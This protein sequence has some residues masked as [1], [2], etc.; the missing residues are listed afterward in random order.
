[1]TQPVYVV[2]YNRGCGARFSGRT[3]TDNPYHPAVECAYL[4]WIAGW[5]DAGEEAGATEP[6]NK[7][8]SPG[9]Q[10][11]RAETETVAEKG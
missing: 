1:V 9:P 5:E 7:S 6:G 3:V 8:G 10:S 2:A 11:R 4:S